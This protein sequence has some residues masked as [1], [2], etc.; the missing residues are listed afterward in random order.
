MTNRT[1]FQLG[2]QIL[3]AEIEPDDEGGF[4]VLVKDERGDALAY[5]LSVN[6][7][8]IFL[9]SNIGDECGI[10]LDEDGRMRVV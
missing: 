2:G 8:G 4:A 6:Q 7:H 3:S 10:A 5:L 9:H 1:M